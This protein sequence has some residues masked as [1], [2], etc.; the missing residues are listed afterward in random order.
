M[1][2]VIKSKGDQGGERRIS[3]LLKSLGIELT[4]NPQQAD[5]AIL[6]GGDGTFLF[7]QSKINCPLLGIKTGG[8][9]HY[10]SSS[11]ND[12]L[13]KI[14]KVLQGKEGKD[15]FIHK[16]LRLEATLNGKKLP[17]A[18]NEY[19][20]SPIYTRKMF[21]CKLKVKG[22]ES[23]ERNSGVI[24]YTPTGSTAF[25]SSAGGKKLN[26]DEK[27]IGII[28]LAPYSGK[29]K[30]GE[31]LLNK[32]KIMVECLNQEGEICVDG[33][34]KYTY[35]IKYGDKIVIEKSPNYSQVIGFK[36]L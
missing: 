17:P 19:L 16:F 23:L 22:K 35:K 32:E 7:W 9:G 14:K 15:Y 28:A 31:I 27:K 2:I 5:L 34:E 4:E 8:V 33:Q 36:K 20:I 1:K 3:G 6:L 30:K 25:A 18:L 10:L 29:L 13:E 12:F 24:I 11:K 21:S 26:W